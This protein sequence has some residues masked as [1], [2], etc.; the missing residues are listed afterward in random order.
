MKRVLLTGATG[1]IGRQAL[2]RLTANGYEVHALSSQGARAEQA[3]VQWHHA[4]LLDPAAARSL[5]ERVRPT[6]LLHLAWYVAPGSYW[7]SPENFHWVEA[8]LRLLRAFA[9]CGGRRVV[10]AGSCAEYDWKYGYCSEGVTPLAPDSVYGI[11][12]RS[13]QAMLDA[14][15]R[16]T[17]LSSAWGRMFFLYGPHEHPDRLV[18]STICSLLKGA[19]PRCSEGKAVRDFLHVEDAAG[20]FVA[21]LESDLGGAVNIASGQSTAIR[22]VISK[23]ADR[24]GGH[25]RIEWGAKP[26]PANEPAFLVGDVTRLTTEVRWTPTYDLDSG[27]D[28]TIG[29]WRDRLRS[30]PT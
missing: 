3:G 7:T 30:E 11:C 15:S 10:M 8:T 26:S 21:L 17:E 6:H 19:S 14:F 2:P 13:L 29:W 25:D 9:Q 24:L 27:L 28:Q 20:A 1:F 18:S 12:K 5:I 16:A 22:Q 23:I 4:D